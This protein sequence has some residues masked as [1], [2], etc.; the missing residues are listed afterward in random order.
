MRGFIRILREDFPGHLGRL[1]KQGGSLPRGHSS[2]V[3]KM[4]A[5]SIQ[6]AIKERPGRATHG[7]TAKNAFWIDN[8]GNVFS[9]NQYKSLPSSGTIY[10]VHSHSPDSAYTGYDYAT[11]EVS[12]LNSED[13]LSWITTNKNFLGGRLQALYL[14]Q[15]NGNMEKLGMPA[16]MSKDKRAAFLSLGRKQLRS[17]LDASYAERTEHYERTGKSGDEVYREKLRAFATKHGLVF[18]ENMRWKPTS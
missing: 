4:V 10:M 11:E 17:E 1:G 8:K 3:D 7:H 13:I 15:K 2:G 18:T 16:D 14:I 6:K 12:P 9:Y 5:K